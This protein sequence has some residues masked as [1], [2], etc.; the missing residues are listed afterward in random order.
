MKKQ[1]RLKSKVFLDCYERYLILKDEI[2]GSKLRKIHVPKT[3]KS[4]T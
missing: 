3:K 1:N 4:K 2:E